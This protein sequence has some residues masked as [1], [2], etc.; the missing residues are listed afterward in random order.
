V[1]SDAVTEE[2]GAEA[3][4]AVVYTSARARKK[5]LHVLCSSFEE[6]EAAVWTCPDF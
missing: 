5:G 6:L 1:P 2:V 4:G 3:A